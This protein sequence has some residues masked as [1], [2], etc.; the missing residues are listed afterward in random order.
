MLGAELGYPASR[1]RR[2][3]CLAVSGRSP[4]KFCRFSRPSL[5]L[6]VAWYAVLLLPTFGR[7]APDEPLMCGAVSDGQS[8]V[9]APFRRCPSRHSVARHD[10]KPATLWDLSSQYY[11]AEADVGTNRAKAC[12]SKLQELNTA[13]QVA[14]LLLVLGI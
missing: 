3:F 7:H 10:T 12:L 5:C 8:R 6:L 4:C 13:V 9:A 14:I 11:I 2:M 1:W